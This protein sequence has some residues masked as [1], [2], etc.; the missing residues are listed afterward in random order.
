MNVLP[1][2]VQQRG[3]AL[4][5]HLARVTKDLVLENNADNR[6]FR[7]KMLVPDMQ[8]QQYILTQAR[9]EYKLTKRQ[10][11]SGKLSVEDIEEKHKDL[12][13]VIYGLGECIRHISHPTNKKKV[14][15]QSPFM[16]VLTTAITGW[17]ND[18]YR[19]A[20]TH[21]FI[22]I[23]QYTYSYATL[24]PLQKPE[25]KPV[26]KVPPKPQPVKKTKKQAKIQIDE[27]KRNVVSGKTLA[28]KIIAK[29]KK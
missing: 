5:R 23:A 15:R 20:L 12:E 6:S 27:P 7:V 9:K 14:I 3:A 26:V 28:K 24:P 29:K 18:Q 17:G 25:P 16:N 13:W 4:F 8:I 19:T 1:H 10:F 11:N 21:C 22:D 2:A